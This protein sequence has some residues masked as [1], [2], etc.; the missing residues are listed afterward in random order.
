[1][2][3]PASHP[4]L[5]GDPVLA[6]FFQRLESRSPAQHEIFQLEVLT[7]GVAGK[8]VLRLQEPVCHNRE[9]VRA[10]M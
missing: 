9:L 8:R 4:T 1:M 7:S 5:P 3:A 2:W 6:D 10:E